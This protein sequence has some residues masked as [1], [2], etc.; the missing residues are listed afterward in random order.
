MNATVNATNFSNPDTATALYMI[1]LRNATL[2][3]QTPPGTPLPTGTNQEVKVS[4]ESLLAEAVLSLHENWKADAA[5][6]NATAKQILQI[7]KGS[8]SQAQLNAMLAAGTS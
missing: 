3:A 2:A 4:Y 7:L 6:N 8:P 1:G 5:A